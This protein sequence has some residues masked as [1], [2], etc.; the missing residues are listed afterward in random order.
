MA[1]VMVGALHIDHET[2]GSGPPL[3]MVP[4][5]R[6]SR[7]V[8]LEPLLAPLAEH[9][10]LVLI[11]NRGTG[12]SDKPADS[13]SIEAFADDAAGLLDALGIAQA[14]VFG[15][16]MGGMISQRIA[17]RHPHKV[18]RLVIGC[19]HCG[20]SAAVPAA[21]G[22]M[23]L[24]RLMPNDVLDAREVAHRQEEAYFTPPFRASQRKLLDQLFEILNANPT[25]AFAVA[26]HLAAIEAF[27]G[28]GDLG[29]IRAP[30][31]VLT[32][33]EDRLI[34]P[35]NSRILACGI[36]GARLLELPQAAH[37]FWVEKPRETA[38]ALIGFLK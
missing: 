33:T 17:T 36:A 15:V 2:R 28:C 3:L 23:D 20:R 38:E 29:A 30:T 24:L 32:G 5:F 16:S 19:S 31:L 18:S 1:R 34:V 26:G 14:H 7:A 4:G 37:F 13:Y 25:P 27:D 11:D 35:E 21:H 9:F 22:I 10:T 8:W 12:H 6:R